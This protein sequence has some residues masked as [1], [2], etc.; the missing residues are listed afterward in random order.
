MEW[1]VYELRSWEISVEIEGGRI[2]SVCESSDVSYAAR[3]ILN[4]KLGFASANSREES[5][6]LAKKLARVSEE[7]LSDFPCERPASVSG[8]YDSRIGNVG[9]DYLREEAEILLSS[10]ELNVV[11]A[12][13][14]HSF[15]EVRIENSFGL[16]VCEKSTHSSLVVEIVADSGSGYE[17]EESRSVRLDVEGA[18]KRAEELAKLSAKSE[19]V[20]PGTIDIV[21]SPYAVH[22]LFQNVLYPSLSAENVLKGRSTL[23]IGEHVGNLRLIDDATLEGGLF[24]CSFDDEG[25]RAR[26]KVL[27][28]RSVVNL[29]TD[30]KTSREFGVTANGFREEITQ[31]PSPSP[32]NVIV[33]VPERADADGA[34]YVHYFIGAHTANQVSGDFSLECH[35]AE[36]DG[37]AVR[38][39]VYGNIFEMLRKIIGEVG[40]ARQVENTVSAAIRFEALRVV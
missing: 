28:D 21:L 5:L 2:K 17:V 15:S 18:A 39:M 16:E 25:C 24:S 6:E 23:K 37:K 26:R 9:A 32:S 20:E 36:L 1:E 11:A 27:I 3:V 30:W 33:D 40:K 35:N 19:K 8:I 29:L 12:R 22:Q 4:G 38:C 34:I 31:P 14:T 10:V 13:I 7:E